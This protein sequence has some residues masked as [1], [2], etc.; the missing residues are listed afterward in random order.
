LSKI[1]LENIFTPLSFQVKLLVLS[2]SML[3][4]VKTAHLSKFNLKCYF[5]FL[6][7]KS[8]N[9]GQG[10]CLPKAKLLRIVQEGW[11]K[12]R[13][14]TCDLIGSDRNLTVHENY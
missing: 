3:I 10:E 11:K 13:H 4:T 12:A 8:L 14:L 7:S 9:S 1:S 2:T 5:V 6:C